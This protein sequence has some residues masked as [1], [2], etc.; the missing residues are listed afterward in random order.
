MQECMIALRAEHTLDVLSNKEIMEH[1]LGR[2]SLHLSWWGRSTSDLT[3]KSNSGRIQHPT[4]EELAKQLILKLL[5]SSYMRLFRDL[6][7]VNMCFGNITSS[8]LPDL[9]LTFLIRVQ[10]QLH[11]FFPL[12]SK[13]PSIEMIRRIFYICSIKICIVIL[14][15]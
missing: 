11:A 4:Y 3:A 9:V 12:L 7:S 13:L 10:I 1:A 14:F 5:S 2:Y 8:Y 15:N 6:M